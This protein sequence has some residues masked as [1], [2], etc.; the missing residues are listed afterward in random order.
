MMQIVRCAWKKLLLTMEMWIGLMVTRIRPSKNYPNPDSTSR[1]GKNYYRFYFII[2]LFNKHSKKGS[3]ID[4]GTLDH[5]EVKTETGYKSELFQKS[6]PDPTK[7][8]GP[9]S[10]TL[11]LT[12]QKVEQLNPAKSAS[13][14][15]IV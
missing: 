3:I 6:D 8:A 11:F 5:L 14:G 12:Q 13:L 4:L 10:A 9:G 2:T 1:H 15:R 7:P